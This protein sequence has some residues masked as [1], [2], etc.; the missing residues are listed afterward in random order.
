[1]LYAPPIG[2]GMKVKVLEA[3]ALGTPVVTN[4]QGIEGLDARDGEH[5]GIAQDDAGLVD[6]AIELLQHPERCRR[7]RIA[8]RRLLELQCSPQTTLD[9]IERMHQ[10][11][12]GGDQ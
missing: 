6:R 2:S 7:Y 9:Q 8:A 4:D 11:I 10:A 3:F 5:C 1:M 12:G